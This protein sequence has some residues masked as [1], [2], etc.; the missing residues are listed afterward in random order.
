MFTYVLPKSRELLGRLFSKEQSF[1][2]ELY[3]ALAEEVVVEIDE[4]AIE[5]LREHIDRWLSGYAVPLE[6]IREAQ[7]I[8]KVEEDIEYEMS[9]YEEDIEAEPDANYQ[10]AR[11]FCSLVREEVVLDIASGFGWIPAI[12]SR[13]KHVIAVDKNYSSEIV[14]A[15]EGR[16][17]AGTNIQIFVPGFKTYADFCKAFWLSVGADISRIEMISADATELSRIPEVKRAQV[18]TCFFGLNHIPQWEKVLEEVR[19]A[20]IENMYVALYSE[21]LAK[22]PVKGI[23]DWTEKLGFHIVPIEEFKSCVEGLGMHAHEVE[24]D[25]RAIYRVFRIYRE[26]GQ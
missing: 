18:A 13:S 20:G 23:Y 3:L 1:L 9:I 8:R 4:E 25:N 5:E 19:K 12:L 26:P 7:R 6:A 24:H 21:E 11:E 22:F 17:V 15:P 14:E 2:E 10:F 16:F